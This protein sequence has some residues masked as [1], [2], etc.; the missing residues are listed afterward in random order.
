MSSGETTIQ[1]L[2]KT[3][4]VH[5]YV[6]DCLYLD[7]RSLINE[8]L[9][10]RKEWLADAIREET[11]YRVS[12]HVEDGQS[13]F[14]A[15]KHHGLEGIMAKKKDSKYMPGKR[16]DFWIKVKVRQ[17]S[18]CYIIGYTKGKGDRGHTFGAMHI[19]EKVGQEFHYRGKVGTGF[20]DST[21]KE[22]SAV[23]KNIKVIKKPDVIGKL[24]DE[25]ISVWLEPTAMAEISYSKLTPDNMFREP[26]F[27]RLRPDLA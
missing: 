1:K 27:I 17:S 23:L 6:F 10:K 19:A 11:P 8:P 13:L 24:L 7:G 4:P 18:E 15:A 14:E 25:K 12:E 22:I 9:L 26:V 21:M 20:D 5:C 16:S 3:Y 2:S